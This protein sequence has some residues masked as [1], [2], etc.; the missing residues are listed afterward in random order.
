MGTCRACGAGLRRK[1]GSFC[2][3]SPILLWMSGE[4]KS[5]EQTALLPFWKVVLVLW[6]KESGYGVAMG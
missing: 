4:L 3:V 5:G 6:C 1:G 2:T